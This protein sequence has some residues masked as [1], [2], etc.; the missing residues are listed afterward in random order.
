MDLI[1]EQQDVA[2]GLD[3]LED[4]LQALF[5]VAAVTRTG[6][7]GTEIERVELLAGERV[8]HVV[9]D[10]LLGEA[11]DDGGLADTGLAD[12]HRVVLGSARQDLHDP[13]EF[14]GTS[15]HRIELA[16]AGGLGE[17]AAELVEDLTVAT[18]FVVAALAGTDAG[19]GRGLFAAA[20]TG[21]TRRALV[22]GEQLDDLLAHTGEIGAELDEHLSGDAFTF[23]D[24]PEQDVLGTDVVVAEL[25]C[26]TQG[27]FEDFLR[28]R[29]EGDVT[30]RRRAALADDLLDLTAHGFE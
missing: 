3:F 25:E 12:E 16:I 1:D 4:L 27:Q 30:R 14:V 23:T 10:D 2:S 26:F 28:T 19:A 9:V 11:L 7:Q 5:E 17:V 21:G 6:H 13:L 18:L 24:E 8:G 20:A 29:R 15:D 22:A